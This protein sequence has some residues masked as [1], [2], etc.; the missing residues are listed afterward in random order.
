MKK[1]TA[2]WDTISSAL[3]ICLPSSQE[4]MLLSYLNGEKYN[5]SDICK[6]FISRGRKSTSD[7]V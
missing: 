5:M 6:C 4:M 2:E 1:G 7:E 3:L